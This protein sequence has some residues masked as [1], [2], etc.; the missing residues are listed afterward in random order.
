MIFFPTGIAVTSEESAR[1]YNKIFLLKWLDTGDSAIDAFVA[2]YNLQWVKSPESNWFVGAGPIDHNNGI[3]GTNDDIKKTK[4][5]RDK[6]KLA[7]FTS[8]ALDIVEGWSKKDDSRLYADKAELLSLKHQ[9]EGF[10]WLMQNLKDTSVLKLRQKIYV[11]ASHAKKFDIKDLVKKFIK[12]NDKLDY[13]DGF[14]EWKEVK[15]S[16]YEL[17]DDGQ[18]FVCSC[19][20]GSEKYF[21]KHSVGLAIKFKNLKIP[22]AA[23]SVPLNE[24]R[25]RGRIA[26]NKGLLSHV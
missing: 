9:T 1:T 5:I 23:K 16:L 11:L 15:S 4:V 21:C 7:P 18:F 25:S 10:Q 8:N 24:K 14:D 17:T 13:D 2:Y 19:P 6:Q 3:E 26:K 12:H 22:D 20:V